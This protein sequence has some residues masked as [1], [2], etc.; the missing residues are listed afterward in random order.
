MVGGLDDID[1]IDLISSCSKQ[2][3]IIWKYGMGECD[4]KVVVSHDHIIDI[5]ICFSHDHRRSV[6]DIAPNPPDA[7]LG[8]GKLDLCVEVR[9]V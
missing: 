7:S 2:V 8:S 3:E 1:V 9:S 4:R 6:P 5:G